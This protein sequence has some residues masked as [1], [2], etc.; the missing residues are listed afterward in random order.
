MKYS[1]TNEVYETQ[2]L[3]LQRENNETHEKL[4]DAEEKL[5]ELSQR[6]VDVEEENLIINELKTHI[7]QLDAEVNDKNKVEF[8]NL[9]KKQIYL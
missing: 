3:A 2:I 7:D 9:F 8:L 6:I 1:E 5:L 4:K